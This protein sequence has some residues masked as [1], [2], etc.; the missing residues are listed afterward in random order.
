MEAGGEVIGVIPEK[1][2]ALELGKTDITE[3]I[4]V[5][6]MHARKKQMADLSDAF[7]ALPGG[8]GTMEELFEAI[9]WTQL[10]YHS[11]PVGLLDVAGYYAP[12]RAFLAHMVQEG[13]VRPLHAPLVQSHDDASTLLDALAALKLP[14]LASWIDDV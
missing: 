11:K 2:Q 1:L 9:T 3:L 6:D 4:V 13:F 7:I 12:L 8:Y 5:P 14:S 10:A